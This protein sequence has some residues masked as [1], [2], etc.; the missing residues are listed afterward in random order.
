[1][2]FDWTAQEGFTPLIRLRPPEGEPQPTL[3]WDLSV[4]AFQGLQ[5]VALSLSSL[6]T[7][8]RQLGGQVLANGQP[9]VAAVQIQSAEI[10]GDSSST[11]KY[12]LD[13]ETNGEGVFGA[14]L[15]PGRYRV[16]ARPVDPTKAVAEEEIEIPPGEGCFCGQSIVVPSKSVL[17]GT[18]SG[19][20]GEPMDP[21]PVVVTPSA[22]SVTRYIDKVL[23]L[24]PL[25]PREASSQVAGG[26]FGL[27]VDPGTFDFSVRPADGSGYPW[28][29]QPRLLVQAATSNLDPMTVPYPAI[30]HGVIRDAAAAALPGA[31]V[32]AWLPVTDPAA[33]GQIV[34]VIQLGETL[35]RV[36]GS[37]VLPLP[38][39]LSE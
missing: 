28:L 18:V 13:T 32:R 1:V 12:K 24:Q 4:V 3:H 2:D 5:N 35:A 34:G 27:Q 30:L 22:S 21:A 39:S 8:P 11:G 7:E 14:Y 33:N 6:N 20:A 31:V 25:L 38:P 19:P 9:V 16:V 10:M 15:P 23:L 36:D 37:Y 17:Q 29:V 26:A